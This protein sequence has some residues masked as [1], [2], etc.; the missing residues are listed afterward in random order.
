MEW[1]AATSLECSRQLMWCV[2]YWNWS[3]N[4]SL[5]LVSLSPPQNVGCVLERTAATEMQK[6]KGKKKKAYFGV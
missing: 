4:E 3:P 6:G 2:W 5:Y 1:G